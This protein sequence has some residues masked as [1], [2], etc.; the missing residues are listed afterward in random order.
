V[1]LP[2]ACALS[3]YSLRIATRVVRGLRVKRDT[4][5]RNVERDGGIVFSQR[6]LTA[7]IAEA[8][9][10]RERAYRAVQRLAQRAR[11]GE[12]GFRELVQSDPEVSAALGP[13]TLAACFD[14]TAYL[15]QIDVT[16]RRLGV[17]TDSDDTTGTDEPPRQALA[18]EAGVAGAGV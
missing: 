3:A 14:I 11:D 2:D 12:G 1:I 7:L 9:W 16:Y 8:Q 18:V 17:S 4:M 6:V 13:V 15:A 10:P 5:T